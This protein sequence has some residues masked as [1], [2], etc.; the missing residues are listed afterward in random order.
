MAATTVA[1]AACGPEVQEAVENMSPRKS[2]PLPRS[3]PELQHAAGLTFRHDGRVRLYHKDRARDVTRPSHIDDMQDGHTVS[4]RACGAPWGTSHVAWASV[5]HSDFVDHG[6]IEP[7]APLGSDDLSVLTDVSRGMPLDGDSCY[8]SDYVQHASAR[9]KQINPNKAPYPFSTHFLDQ[10]AA[11]VKKSVYRDQFGWHDGK[12]AA[13]ALFS[14]NSSSLTKATAGKRLEGTT[15]YNRDFPGRTGE[16]GHQVR[17]LAEAM[18]HSCLT[19]RTRNANFKGESTYTS[20]Y[21]KHDDSGRQPSCRPERRR[22]EHQA[23]EG[24]SEHR[25][26]YRPEAGAGEH[27]PILWLEDETHE[28]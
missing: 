27:R 28:K 3:L 25:R 23:F 4:V 13:T 9:Q 5:H 18:R 24:N 20:H 1:P 12:D 17:G 16:P 6:Q 14:D 7:P 22:E 8:R 26:A 2:I 11:P 19:E 21:I 15:S 10:S